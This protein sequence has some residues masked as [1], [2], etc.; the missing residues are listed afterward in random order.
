VHGEKMVTVKKISG[1]VIPL[2]LFNGSMWKNE[3]EINKFEWK[4]L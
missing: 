4:L 1:E 2:I 3:E